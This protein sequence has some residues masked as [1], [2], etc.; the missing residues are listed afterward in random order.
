LV[1]DELPEAVYAQVKALSAEGDAHAE[2]GAHDAALRCY[3]DALRLL[4]EP[5]EKWKAATWLLAAIA[6]VH[7]SAKRFV[8]VRDAVSD[9]MHCPG[10]I[11]NPFLHL[12]LG[13]AC[14]ELG[15]LDRAADELIRAYMGAGDEVFEQEDDKY[16]AFLKTRA[17]ID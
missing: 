15:E 11:G 14:F 16:L 4:P 12:R 10:A 13:Q 6:D 8:A 7:F 5:W 3:A 9:A 2:S 1:E 17:K